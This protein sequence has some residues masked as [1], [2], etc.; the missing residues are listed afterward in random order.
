LEILA[1]A[2][3]SRAGPVSEKIKHSGVNYLLTFPEAVPLALLLGPKYLN[4]NYVPLLPYDPPNEESIRVDYRIE[5]ELIHSYYLAASDIHPNQKFGVILDYIEF[6]NLWKVFF[7]LIRKPEVQGEIEFLIV[8]I[9][10]GRSEIWKEKLFEI[11]DIPKLVLYE[12][13]KVDE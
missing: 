6:G 12:M 13:K 1:S 10:F 2:I 4:I 8:I 7:D 11:E 3:I 5:A 9:G